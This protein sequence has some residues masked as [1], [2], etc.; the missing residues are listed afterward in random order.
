[1]KIIF[2]VIIF[3]CADTFAGSGLPQRK[4]M[5]KLELPTL[6]SGNEVLLSFEV[7]WPKDHKLNKKA[8][9]AID[10][11]E[12]KGKAWVKTSTYK[13]KD[14]FSVGGKLSIQERVRLKSTDSY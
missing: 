13:M 9:S 2:A 3:L 11:Y 12:M 10:V 7:L 8:P 14:Y 4:Q 6:K 1:M 5:T